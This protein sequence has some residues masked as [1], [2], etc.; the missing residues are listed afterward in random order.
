MKP[1]TPSADWAEILAEKSAARWV[2]ETE[3]DVPASIPI[4]PSMMGLPSAL[5]W[6]TLTAIPLDWSPPTG[7]V[8]A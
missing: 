6:P 5:A 2:S 3:H 8:A 1:A 4:S 7:V